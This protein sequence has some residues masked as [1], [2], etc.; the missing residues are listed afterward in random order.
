VQNKRNEGEG[1]LVCAFTLSYVQPC[2][3]SGDVSYFTLTRRKERFRLRNKLNVTVIN[4]TLTGYICLY[5]SVKLNV[6]FAQEK[7]Y[8]G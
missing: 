8:K 4:L 1:N 7:A 6:L 2:N 5:I 3:L